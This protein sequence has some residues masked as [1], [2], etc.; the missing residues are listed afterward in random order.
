MVTWNVMGL[1][2]TRIASRWRRT[3]ARLTPA[4]SLREN[5][6]FQPHLAVSTRPMSSYPRYRVCISSK[7]WT[8]VQNEVFDKIF[9]KLEGKRSGLVYLVLYDRCRHRDGR[10]I[11]AT[12]AEI[13]RWCG[14]D[15]RSVMKCLEELESKELIIRV[16]DGVK[17]S[18]INKPRWRVPLTEFELGDGNWTPIPRF[19]FTKYCRR[20]AGAVL[21]SLLLR[22]QH[23]HKQ[24]SCWIGVARLCK[25]TGWSESRV[26]DAI[27]TMGR[28]RLWRRRSKSLP[29]PL[30]IKYN[31]Q[32]THRRFRVL[33]VYY[34][35]KGR[36]GRK[37]Y[38]MT[39][40]E[41]FRKRFK[42]KT[43]LVRDAIDA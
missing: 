29:Q 12:I 5:R 4:E 39:I 26:R 10:K 16:R 9:A 32:R 33:A 3:F 6:I 27:R 31:P 8:P 2:L 38:S 25:R 20:Y 1:D 30:E 7:R 11:S 19:L 18:H 28:E 22:Y 40:S 35:S 14:I 24:N 41:E 42:I 37:V 13:T 15:E 17:R 43:T 36:K 23:I 34:E 21:L